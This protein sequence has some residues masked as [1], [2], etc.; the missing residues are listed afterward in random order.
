M[1][2]APE[3]LFIYSF[4]LKKEGLRGFSTSSIHEV[5]RPQQNDVPT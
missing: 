5:K 4:F 1:S 3:F 2:L